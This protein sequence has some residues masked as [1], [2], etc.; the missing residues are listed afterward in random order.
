M[1]RFRPS[2][3]VFVND[4]QLHLLVFDCVNAKILAGSFVCA[5]W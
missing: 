5:Q 1:I 2:E 4:N 3:R